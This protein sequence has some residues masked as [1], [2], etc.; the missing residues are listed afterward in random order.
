MNEENK[1]I[2]WADVENF[3]KT[4]S[5]EE[6]QAEVFVECEDEQPPRRIESAER[7]EFDVWVYDGDPENTYDSKDGL[8]ALQDDPDESLCVL[9]TPKGAPFIC[10][11]YK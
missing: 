9:A 2:T 8:L 10:L 1:K 3:I 4:L 6:K 11:E 7:A 5:E